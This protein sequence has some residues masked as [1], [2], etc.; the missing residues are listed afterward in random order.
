MG[1]G[2]F[3]AGSDATRALVMV[4]AVIGQ[5]FLVTMLARVVGL[6]GVQRRADDAA[7]DVPH[8]T[9]PSATD[10]ERPRRRPG[11]NRDPSAARTVGPA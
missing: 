6:L 8:P 1:F 10:H 9:R 4:E 3:T 7:P 5:V 2:D 11:P